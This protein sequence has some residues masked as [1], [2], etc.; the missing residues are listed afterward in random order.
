MPLG[1]VLLVRHGETD[2]NTT[3]RWQGQLDTP[4]NLL[5]RQ[6]A[7]KVALALR[8]VPLSLIVSSD[9]S[10][11]ADTARAIAAHHG[12]T[13]V[14]DA[15]WREIHLGIFQG[16]TRQ[17]IKEIYPLE[18]NSW[19]HDDNFVVPN[20]E[21]RLQVQKR[22]HEA[23]LSLT[24]RPDLEGT[25][26]VTAHGGTIRWLLIRL[27]GEEATLGRHL[28]NTSITTLERSE[29]GAW[30]MRKVGDVAHLQV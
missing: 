1:R 3:G 25:A 23:W 22:A 20:G 11:A 27:F 5:G 16:L 2:Y 12:L 14:L 29:D 9:L 10:R 21:S 13:P 17:E 26:L 24:E 7:E 18:Y 4:L 6:Q 28:E 15:R 19:H 8:N 30:V